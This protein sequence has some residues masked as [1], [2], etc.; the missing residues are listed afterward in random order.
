MFIATRNYA[1]QKECGCLM[2][3]TPT[4]FIEVYSEAYFCSDECTQ[5]FN[6]MY[7]LLQA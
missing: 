4:K 3:H 7:T 6:Q 5:A 1:W 2:C